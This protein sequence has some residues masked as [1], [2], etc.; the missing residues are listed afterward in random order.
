MS[1]MLTWLRDE[2]HFRVGK[3]ITNMHCC[4]Q[5]RRMC[6]QPQQPVRLERHPHLVV[7]FTDSM[8]FNWHP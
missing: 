1:E 2:L 8:S 7:L 6:T 4:P 5:W 3:V